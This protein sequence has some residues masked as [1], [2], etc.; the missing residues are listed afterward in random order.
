MKTN[1]V[2]GTH[3]CTGPHQRSGQQ[4]GREESI[5][6]L[7]TVMTARG[8]GAATEVC[9]KSNVMRHNERTVCTGKVFDFPAGGEIKCHCE[10]GSPPPSLHRECV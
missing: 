7:T 1:S 9:A 2:P 3:G 4:G 8:E 10:S 5:G 6:A